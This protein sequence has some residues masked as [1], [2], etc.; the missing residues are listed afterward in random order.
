MQTWFSF[1]FFLNQKKKNQGGNEISRA[2]LIFYIKFSFKEISLFSLNSN[3]GLP[4]VREISEN[5]GIFIK[6]T[7][8]N[9][10]NNSYNKNIILIV[11]IIST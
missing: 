10:K 3:A 7:G 9:K 4:Q 8:K 2:G 5:S 11:R 1:L 6:V